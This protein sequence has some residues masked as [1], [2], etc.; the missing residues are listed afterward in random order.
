MLQ[1]WPPC[2]HIP[3]ATCLVHEMIPPNWRP[4]WVPAPSKE[5]V[6]FV[7][8]MTGRSIFPRLQSR[9]SKSDIKKPMWF[10]YVNINSV[11]PLKPT[12]TQPWWWFYFLNPRI[13]YTIHSLMTALFN[14]VMLTCL[15]ILHLISFELTH[16]FLKTSREYKVNNWTLKRKWIRH[17]KVHKMHDSK[18]PLD[19]HVV[20]YSDLSMP[21]KGHEISSLVVRTRAYTYRLSI[22][23]F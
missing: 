8:G 22:T 18:V 10:E 5:T 4:L 21:G 7:N 23:T 9:L 1:A 6:F 19:G 3:A 14:R 11:L 16:P 13:Q 17:R 20:F 15:Q 12:M 2:L